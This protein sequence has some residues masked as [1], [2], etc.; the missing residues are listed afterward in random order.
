MLFKE[1]FKS[2][3]RYKLIIG[4]ITDSSLLNTVFK[5]YNIDGVINFAAE[6]HVDNS[7]SDPEIFIKTNVNGVQLI[8]IP[9]HLII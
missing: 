6:T 2:N 5:K 1:K 7:I 4:D 8:L 9:I 3:S